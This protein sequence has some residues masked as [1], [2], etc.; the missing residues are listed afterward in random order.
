MRRRTL[1]RAQCLTLV[2]PLLADV[3]LATAQAALAM[4]MR[5]AVRWLLRYLEKHPAATIE[6][7]GVVAACLRALGSPRHDEAGQT[8]RV[9]AERSFR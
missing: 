8:L 2:R 7:A 4:A 9:M 1:I 5:V 3:T 6:E